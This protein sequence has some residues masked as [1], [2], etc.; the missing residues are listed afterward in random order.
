MLLLLVFFPRVRGFSENVRQFIP[1]LLSFFFLKWRLARAHSFH[2]LG[3]DQSAVAQRAETT[4]CDRV[5]PGELR[6][7]SFPD[8]FPHCAWTAAQSAHSDFVGSKVYASLGVTFHLY[9]WQ[10]DRDLLPATA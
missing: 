8:R 9:F 2:S 7:S 3:P 5:F 4:D 10:N 6:V 1:R